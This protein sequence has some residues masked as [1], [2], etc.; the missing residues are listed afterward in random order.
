MLETEWLPY[1]W[2]WERRRV[3]VPKS[4]NF[5]PRDGEIALGDFEWQYR[6]SE[7]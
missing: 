4:R 3:F 7:R 1:L 6:R 5:I 2:L